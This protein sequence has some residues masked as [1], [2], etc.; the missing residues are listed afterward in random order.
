MQVLQLRDDQI[1]MLPPEQ[2]QSIL[3]LKEQITQSAGGLMP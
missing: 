1:A 3:L 2:R